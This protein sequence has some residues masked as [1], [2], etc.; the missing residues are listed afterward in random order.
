LPAQLAPRLIVD[1]VCSGARPNEALVWRQLFRPS[2]P[3]PLPG[4][5][6]AVL[7]SQ[8]GSAS[9]HHRL[10][11]KQATAELLAGAGLPIPHLLDVIP[12]GGAVNAS[13]PVWSRPEGVF[14]KPRHGSATRGAM[15]GTEF[16]RRRQPLPSAD[17]LLVQTRLCATPELADLAT[18]GAAPVL[19]LT[20]ARYPGETPFLHSALISITVPGEQPRHFIRGQIR[21]AINATSGLMGPGIWFLH[22][23]ERYLKLPWNGA[24]L[25]GRAMPCLDLAVEMAMRAMAL[26]PGLPLVSW[27]IIVT[28]SGPVILEG[29]TCGD[30][31]LTNLSIAQ[32]IETIPLAP[33]LNRWAQRVI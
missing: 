16:L 3:H 9:E 18:S 21:V 10:A 5:A 31:I 20:T 7:L 12:R 6:A 23:R 13:N 2:G 26:V 19:R 24:P 30:W 27:D 4:R 15:T 1:C 8:L 33:L 11:D 32:G 22:S 29:N 25:A 28:H 14:V 17:E